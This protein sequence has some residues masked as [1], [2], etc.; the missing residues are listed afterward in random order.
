MISLRIKN[1]KEREEKFKKQDE[2][3][4]KKKE[5]EGAENKKTVST[6]QPTLDP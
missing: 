6:H 1:K 3:E 2:A 5:K 4:K